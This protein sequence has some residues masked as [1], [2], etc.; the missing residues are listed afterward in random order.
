MIAKQIEIR[1]NIKKYFDLAYEGDAVIVPRKENKNVVIISEEEYSRLNEIARLS[2]YSDVAQGR[3]T[4]MSRSSDVVS[5]SVKADNLKKL[6]AIARLKDDWNGN[7]AKAFEKSFISRIQ[8]L[9]DQLQIQ[10]EI[11]PTAL[12]TIQLEFD[13]SRRDH[14]EIEI[15]DDKTAEIFVVLYNGEEYFDHV[16]VTANALNRKVAQFYE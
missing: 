1:S 13:N 2:A 15:G 11:F 9:I 10:P 7:G 12:Q 14:M 3:G 4:D 8:K 5:S 6:D 16:A